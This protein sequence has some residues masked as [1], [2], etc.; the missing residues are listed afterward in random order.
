M[1]T[2]W[3]S[4]LLNRLRVSA[5][6]HRLRQVKQTRR[7]RSHLSSVLC[8]VELLEPRQLLSASPIG[9]ETQVNTTNTGNQLTTINGQG[10]SIA[11]DAVGDYV[12]TW[13]SN[14]GSGY[15]VYAQR[16]N[17]AGIAQAGEFRVN[18]TTVDNQ[19]QP[20]VAMDAA[21]DFVVTWSSSG[22]DGSG[23]GVYG[24]RYN[25]AGVAQGTEFQVNTTTAGDQS[26]PTVAM[27]AVGDFVVTWYGNGSGDGFGVYAQRY[28]T[29]GVKQGGEFQVNTT[30]ANAQL[31]STVAMDA[32]GNFVVTWSSFSQDNVDGNAG[33]YAQRYNAAG[34]AQGTEFQV[35]TYT[36]SY[37]C[38]STVTMDAAGDFVITWSSAGQDG[39]GYGVYA[40]RYSAVGVAQGT[41]FQVNTTTA[42]R[43]FY[44]TVAMDAAGDFVV[45]WSSYGQDG[46]GYGV[47]AQRYNAAGVAQGTEFPVNTTTTDTQKFSTVAMDAAGDFVVTWSSSGQ[48]GSGWGVYAQRYDESTD[49]AGPI[50]A[51]VF[52]GGR[53]IAAGDQLVSVV[54]A[55]TVVFSEDLDVTGG[56]GGANSVTNSANW[57]LTRNGVDVS[58]TIS[59]ITFGLN[60]TTNK[61]EAVLTFS[62][63]LD[64]GSFALTAKQSIQDLSGNALDGD[65]SGA[66]GGDFTQSFLIA[67]I[68]PAGD[69]TQVNT[70]TADIQLTNSSGQGGST[71]MDAAG[72]YV[73]TWASNGQDGSSF[74]VYAQRYNAAGVAQGGEFQVNTTTADTQQFST[75]AM[76]ADGDFVVTWT[77]YGQDGSAAGVY[78]QRYNAAGV[79]QGTEFQVNT[80]T[81][82]NQRYSTVA[83]DAAGDFVV[84]WT[85]VGQ[86]GSGAGVYAQRY[87]AAGVTQ[88]GEF[89]VN[90]TTASDQYLST[91]AMNAAGDF[92]ITW[93]SF[94]QDGIDW[95]VY[96]Q[97]Y[98]SAGVAQGGE[99]RVNT[100]TANDQWFSSVAMDAAGDFVVA[101]GS[102]GQDGSSFG[103]YAQR[104]QANISP[105]LTTPAAINLTDTAVTDT[106]SDQTGTLSATDADLP[107]QPLTY[108]IS[109][110]TDNGDGTVS[111]VGTY[112]TLTVTTATGA[113]RYTP[114]AAAINGLLSNNTDSFDV[115]VSDGSLTDTKSL[116]VNITAV[117]DEPVLSN[118]ETGFL[119]YVPQSPAM[120]ITSTLTL[121][122]ADSVTMSG[123]TIQIASGF[124][125]GDVLA[126]VDANGIT[127]SY[128]GAGT[129]TLTGSSSLANYQAA[130]QSVTFSSSTQDPAA[131]TIA[132]TVN[133]GTNDSKP[134]RRTV[135]TETQ[136]NTTTTNNQSTNSSGQGGSTAMD[137]EGDYVVTWT[138]SGQDGSGD[139]VY[140]QR[141]NA[142][143]IAQGTE[144]RVNTTTTGHQWASTVAMDAAGDFVVTWASS[145]QDGSGDGV[146]AQRYNAAGVAQGGEFRVNTTTVNDQT[147]ST[148][149]MDAAGDFVVTWSSYAQDGHGW[150]IYAQ[151]YDA[152]GV[153]QGG[154]F[155]VNTATGNYQIYPTVAMDA[156]G[157]FVVTWSSNGQD[158]DSWGVYAQRYDAAGMAQ[159]GEFLVN[160]TTTGL[161]KFSTVAMDASG[162]F[163]VTWTSNGQD[164]SSY[165]IYAQR[166]DAAGMAQGG[167]FQVNTTTA[168]IQRF[169]T[170]AIDAA[171]DFVVTWQSYGQDGSSYGVYAQRYDAAGVAQGGEFLVNTTT[172][173]TQGYATVAMD[174]AGDFVVAWSSAGQDDS[175]YGVYS[176]RYAASTDAAGPI[177]AQVFDGGRQIAAGDRLV[178]V[179][180]ALTVVFSE[181]LDVTGGASGANS[182]TNPANWVLTRNGVD[183]S[184]TISGITFGLN[185]T[186]NKYEAVLTFSTAL[187]DGSFALTAKQSIQDLS[188]NALDG[189]FSGAPGGDFTQSFLI[190]TIVPA[191]DET[192]VNTTTADI[193]L[194]N[195]SG[196]GGSTAMDAAGNYVVTWASN[197]Q[198][199]SSFGVYAQRY[200]AAGV[201]QGGEFQVN[202]TTAGNQ[203]SSTVAMDPAGNFV[204]TWRSLNQDGSGNGVYAQRYDAAGVAQGGEFLVNT[205]T[206]GN[207]SNSTVAMDAAG[208]FVVTWSSYGQDGS[209]YGVYAQRYNAAG[210]AQGSE[211]QVNTTTANDQRLSTVA[212]N[213]A[214]DF[215]VTWSSFEQDGSAHGVYAQRYD[216][217]GVAQGGEFQV[218]TTTANNQI[219]ST[220]AMDAT[221]DF[222]VTWSSYGQDG[223]GNGVYAQRYDAAGIA[224]GGE[225]LVNTTTAGDQL[226]STVAMD[227]D[228]NF[229]VAW[230]SY[231]QDGSGYG[232]YAQRYNA[233]GVAQGG[234][235]QVST[236]SAN[237]QHYSSV[238]MDATGD[239]VV[240]W[241]SDGQDGSS[242][243][244]YAQRYQTDISPVLTTPTAINLTDTAATDTF[245]DQTGTL[246]ATD[247][248]L[249]AQT[250]TYGVSGGTD[251]GDGTVSQVGTY[252]TLTVTT[253]T[254][255]YRY[256][257]D[258]AAINRLL[259]DNADSFDVTVSDGSLT[260]TRS[261]PV[262]I[263]AANDTPTLSNLETTPLPYLPNAPA[264]VITS[265]LVV[266]DVDSTQ[267]AGATI[268]IS[269][270]YQAGDVLG[271][272]DTANITGSFNPANGTLT[273]TGTDTIAGYQAALRSITYVTSSQSLALRTV[274]FQVTDGTSLSSGASRG[275]GGTAQLNGSTLY[276]YGTAAANTITIDEAAT[277]DVVVDGV[278]TQFTPAQVTS[279]FVFGFDGDDT[280]QI[281]SLANGTALTAYGMN[282]NDTLQVSAAVTQGVTLNGAAGNDLL[283]GGSSN[284]ALLG[285]SDNDWLNGGEGSDILTAGAGND[286]YAFSDGAVNQLDTIVELASEGTDTLNFTA[287]TATVTVNLTSD[288]A[289][290]IMAHRIV[291]VGSAGQ[292]ANLENVSGG[293]GNDFITGNASNNLLSGN[294][295]NDTL[296]GGDGSDQL[297]G[298]EGNDLLK[299]GNQGDVLLGGAGADYLMG[300]AGFDLLDGGDGFN[301][302]VGGTEGDTYRFSAATIDQIDTI[303]ELAGE[304][305]D[306]LNFAALTTAV[307]VNLT[308]DSATA[309]MAHRI[310]QTGA[311]QSANFENVT[312]GSGNDQI[313]GNSADN[314]LLGNNG[315]DTLSGGA[316]HDILLGGAGNDTLKGISGRN[317][318]IGGT[319]ADLLLGGTDDDLLLSGSSSYESDP[320]VLQA[321]L[322]EWASANPYQT[323]VDHLLGNTP[324]G[325]NSTFTLKPS[326]VTTDTDTDYLTGGTGQD[327][328]L[329]NAGQDSLTDKAVDEVFT[330]IDSWI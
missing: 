168:G 82:G 36:T 291:Q 97:R 238:A 231:G 179:V 161:Q 261:L 319:G 151:R 119:P 5:N 321:L 154:E 84:T 117:N 212:M 58:N 60:P 254:G 141:Y 157:D 27:D 258:A 226:F 130:L 109:G 131:R 307:N 314:V 72:N 21:G 62:T 247:A 222:V 49:L 317:I 189:D 28:N 23:D 303:V 24:Q 206:A 77:S 188:G 224:Q 264:T 53:Q 234:E 218:N 114:D 272:A 139:G 47:Y 22:Q 160:T 210:V 293:S 1:L 143:G 100:A 101:W 110:G 288:T 106:F 324:G 217:A 245:S 52:D 29:A 201:A 196:Q 211:F 246:S 126:F 137:A 301:T 184:N 44:S 79:A 287:L 257:P 320:G 99:F 315:N 64:D 3:F 326:T 267:M 316:G 129:L 275:V 48:D 14:D 256:T 88:G 167:E 294:G 45:T 145:G 194:T 118:L 195:S 147:Y 87:N 136:V 89:Q 75:V 123:A 127:G 78:A 20:T 122:D 223:G 4:K 192:Q 325:A 156:A 283:I 278:L 260:D 30:T 67:T 74:G 2:N 309:T 305:I 7:S 94:G 268:Q 214:G 198:D 169:S 98:N 15:G 328:F 229:V 185:P 50:V 221:G 173:A 35:N 102:D 164:G 41:E 180:P 83:M 144:F 323:R 25:A 183:V 329:A 31:S 187:D 108:G 265:T 280:I 142:A 170:V 318:L 186:T 135:S 208:D 40:Q 219:F 71:A 85:S 199:G 259:S 296:I 68:V 105:V 9:L 276:V 282:G 255:A 140:A 281:N 205:T 290:A 330:H 80:T 54:P 146:Y 182:V 302:L 299:G 134:V 271:F 133:D 12:V 73:V 18:T 216:A 19:S 274:T 236:T 193:Q 6:H 8:I 13:M 174:A 149:A 228:G 313:T 250:L 33:V 263:T 159:G 91:V 112:G 306:S 240:A 172:T 125:S 115:T 244:V 177:V 92:G 39:S 176:Q 104:Y 200:N 17:A 269:G 312:G 181:D 166:Y 262:N 93:Q 63:A 284:D 34:V 59:G 165:G 116:P 297:D 121:A 248:D 107:A 232:V 38:Y 215:V 61:Y 190:A 304:G 163:V 203:R 43:Q 96:A 46:S 292:S 55:L 128:D 191:G 81:T 113:Y 57:V 16:Y 132:F 95:D 171:G 270:G 76:D 230:S 138:S 285:G 120:V 300:E 148:V 241:S 237:L 11:A 227:A 152:A 10:G 207:Q 103:V 162:D 213:A 56:A 277:L 178:S 202:T 111:Q 70:T 90:T 65:F 32:A 86:D 150:G 242:F 37:Q 251:N 175:G 253:A 243:G 273:L 225:F 239:F 252:G 197:G 233:A 295:G 69:E 322:A 311:S 158:G 220:V 155:Q 204:I 66:P 308:S 249:P 124:Q 26:Q 327:W 153:A 51:Q 42:N 279:V 310:V 298:G 209:G 235:F 289:L 266:K 286:V